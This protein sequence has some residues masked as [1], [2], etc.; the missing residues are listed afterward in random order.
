MIR[1]PSS[2][3]CARYPCACVEHEPGQFCLCAV[4]PV[5][6]TTCTYQ[7]TTDVRLPA[8][9]IQRLLSQDSSPT[10]AVPIEWVSRP[11][12]GEWT[13]VLRDAAASST[14]DTLRIQCP[15]HT[16]VASSVTLCGLRVDARMTP[17][18]LT[19]QLTGRYV[20]VG[21]IMQCAGA[22]YTV[23][24]IQ[25]KDGCGS[26][27]LIG[28]DCRLKL[29]D[30]GF[31]AE[32]VAASSSLVG[33]EKESETLWNLVSFLQAVP[34]SHTGAVVHG[35][36]GCGVSSLV[37]HVSAAASESEVYSWRPTFDADIVARAARSRLLV[38]TIP[39]CE[40]VFSASETEV[41]RLTLR[42]LQKDVGY[43]TTEVNG[44]RPSVLVLSSTHHL[45][46]CD[47]EVMASFFPHTVSLTLPDVDRRATLIAH[48]RRGAP[49][50]WR[51]MAQSLVG[52]TVAATLDAAAR[53]DWAYQ[54]PFRPVQ[55]SAI[56]GLEAVK[57]RLHRA[58][59]W[60]QQHPEA[61]QRFSLDPPKGVL[62]YGPPGCAKTTL[63]KALC[64]EGSFSLI[65]LDSAI[66]VSAYV[67]ESERHLREVFMKAAQQAPCIV[68]FDEVEVIGARRTAGTHDAENVRLLSTLLTELD[69]FATTRGVCFV[70]ATNAPHLIDPALLRPGRFDFI[71]HVPLPDRDDRR[72]ILKLCLEG[73]E[74]DLEALANLTKGFSGA[75]LTSLCSNAL[76]ELLVDAT[77]PPTNMRDSAWMTAFLTVKVSTFQRMTYD[78][79]ALEA[80]QREHS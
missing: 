68:F 39:T 77:T 14:G 26:F 9:Q 62:L 57:T 71:V 4:L 74:A 69:G 58:L 23:T 38:L 72:D 2:W 61:F 18:H 64:S 47:P 1:A 13:F 73:V 29:N 17:A 19:A 27:V 56:G 46:Q 53:G 76:L 65:Y 34:G 49:E 32:K 78:A 51:V 43:L 75:D 37:A 30:Y 42:K 44:Y 80:F 21:S 70:G 36:S 55:W 6:G 48:V 41:A 22:S 15:F 5:L 20:A 28:G 60:P 35:P 24:A 25:R 12:G 54:P 40:C 50:K 33:L 67:G 7:L 3:E 63:V 31:S 52:K 45:G 16:S 11:A 59:V 10:E 8:D 79:A 66:V